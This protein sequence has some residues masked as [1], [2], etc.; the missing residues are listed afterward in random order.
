MLK[1]KTIRDYRHFKSDQ[2]AHVSYEARQLFTKDVLWKIVAF[3]V[4]GYCGVFTYLKVTS[5]E[6]DLM[7]DILGIVLQCITSAGI[8]FGVISY[9]VFYDAIPLL[10]IEMAL[11]KL[12]LSKDEL[13]ELGYDLA[14]CGSNYES[15]MMRLSIFKC[16]YV[17]MTCHGSWLYLRRFG[18]RPYAIFAHL[19]DVE[20]VEKG[21]NNIVEI[22]I[23]GYK[24]SI[25]I[26]T[27]DKRDQSQVRNVIKRGMMRFKKGDS[28]ISELEDVEEK[29]D[30]DND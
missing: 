19:K 22:V 6:Q 7:L 28:I 30:G 2:Y 26:P 8:L 4:V 11:R 18:L 27:R 20:S 12:K 21:E 17:R 24:K 3:M 14:Y 25:I 10:K 29:I 1:K 16:I 13:I 15:Y 9:F 23:S 5:V